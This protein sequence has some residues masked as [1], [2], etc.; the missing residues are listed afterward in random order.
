ML[1]FSFPVAFS[2]IT[3]VSWFGNRFVK[4]YVGASLNI[5]SKG[6]FAVP[7]YIHESN[8][9]GRWMA[10]LQP[11]LDLA[12]WTSGKTLYAIDAMD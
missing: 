10:I 7:A 6:W 9:T 3:E 12:S 1:I 8:G 4:N 11:N 5:K 2:Y